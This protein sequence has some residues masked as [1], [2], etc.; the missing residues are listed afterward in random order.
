VLTS[1]ELQAL[2]LSLQVAALGTVIGLPIALGLSW[3]LAKTSFR[4]KLL[5]DLLISF[6][7]VL[8]PVVMG[9]VLLVLLGRG[10]PVGGLLHR[11]G[12]DLVFT[13]VAAALAAGLV[14]LP[15]MVRTME[16]ALAQVDPRLELAARSLGAGPWRTFATV[17]VPLAYRGILA[18]VL[19]AFARGLGE[20]GATIVVAG[21]IPG[22]T[23]TL[24]LAIFTELQ[25]GDDAGALRFI[26]LS[27]L[28]ALG[29]L[30]LHHRMT[31]RAVP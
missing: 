25:T 16:V 28:L 3:A 12:I 17:T 14:A 26:A 1:A 5:L 10:G 7:L 23:Q 15:L 29:A 9:Y 30:L 6:P 8:P 13:W 11:V 22:V 27:V 19:L 18:G 2:R 31:R 20:F 24:P 4:G 21:N